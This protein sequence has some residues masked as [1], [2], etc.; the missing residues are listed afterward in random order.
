ML[1]TRGSECDDSALFAIAPIALDD[2]EHGVLPSHGRSESSLDHSG[3]GCVSNNRGIK[4]WRANPRRPRIL[5]WRKVLRQG[6]RRHLKNALNVS[7][8]C[9]DEDAATTHLVFLVVV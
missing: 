2:R 3:L 6:S 4:P 7:S 1:A 8:V 5:G 9:R